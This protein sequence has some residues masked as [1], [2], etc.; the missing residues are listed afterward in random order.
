MSATRYELM[1]NLLGLNSLQHPDS[2]GRLAALSCCT[3]G[4]LSGAAPSSI[5][6]GIAA[7]DKARPWRGA[8]AASALACA[9]RLLRAALL[10]LLPDAARL[11]AC[12][13][14]LLLLLVVLH[15]QGMKGWV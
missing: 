7:P 3:S 6:V 8:A 1:V 5:P 15:L 14:G 11:R 12:R 13:R 9:K 10:Q 2:I 4:A